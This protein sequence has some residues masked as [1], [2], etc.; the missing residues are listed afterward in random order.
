M[1]YGK[2]WQGKVRARD[3]QGELKPE[4]IFHLEA[5]LPSKLS[6]SSYRPNTY[7]SMMLSIGKTIATAHCSY[8]QFL[9]L[10]VMHAQAH[11]VIHRCLVDALRLYLYVLRYDGEKIK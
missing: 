5:N 11:T 2:I 9:N 3:A 4:A 10:N 6:L 1:L 7:L 8:I